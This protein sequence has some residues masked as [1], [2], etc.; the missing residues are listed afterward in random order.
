[1]CGSTRAMYRRERLMYTSHGYG[2][3]WRTIRRTPNTS[4]PYGERVIDSPPDVNLFQNC[5]NFVNSCRRVFSSAADPASIGITDAIYDD[6]AI[7]GL[8]EKRAAGVSHLAST[9][10][11]G[12]V[13]FGRT[14][15]RRRA[16]SSCHQ[17]G[18]EASSTIVNLRVTGVSGRQ[19]TGY[20]GLSKQL[21]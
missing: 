19:A 16:S 15:S 5:A 6:L 8:R 3:S 10:F 11:G 4:T 2:R 18:T 13:V 20:D 21:S 17:A 7:I 9:A 1:M 12:I 14:T